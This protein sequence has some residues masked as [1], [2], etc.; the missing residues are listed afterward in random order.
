MPQALPSSQAM[1]HQ[2]SKDEPNSRGSSTDASALPSSVNW[3]NANGPA[4]RTRTESQAA[5]RSSPSPQFADAVLAASKGDNSRGTSA[6]PVEKS[7]PPSIGESTKRGD[8]S[9]ASSSRKA[10]PNI[11]KSSASI[12]DKLIESV[13]S[14]DFR[15]VFDSSAFSAEEL[16]AI[17]RC[18]DLIDPYGGVKRRL[19]RDRE[20]AER[21]KLEAEDPGSSF[22]WTSLQAHAQPMAE[23]ESTEDE[24]VE[25]GSLALGGEPEDPPRNTLSRTT[26]GRPSSTSFMNDQFSNIN[27]NSRNLTP[28]EQ[29]QLALLKS[30][31]LQRAPGLGQTSSQ[32]LGTK[33]EIDQ[34]ASLFQGQQPHYDSSHV[35]ARNH[36]RYFANDSYKS[37]QPP[38]S[39]PQQQQTPAGS[40]HFYASGVQ[41]PPPGLKTAGT[42][43]ISGG[44]MFAQGHG[45]T[46]NMNAGFGTN[47]DNNVDL[48]MR[49]RT[50][51]TSGN[52]FKREYLLS[53]QNTT[54][55]SPPLSAPAHGLF[56]SLH[57]P[58]A[59]AYQ[60][61]TLIK[62]NHH[63]KKGK[64]HGKA[65]T[66]SSGGGVV[67]L[68][69][70]N[71]S[72]ARMHLTNT[73][74][75]QGLF[76]GHNQGGYNQTNSIYSGG[77]GRW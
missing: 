59:V 34:R 64:K 74:T 36:S 60:D 65:N 28:H 50:G 26:I 52:H 41:G 72:Q 53:L 20:A 46:S 5:S 1:A 48:L 54:H 44:G 24:P 2:S 35:H 42:P 25:S 76:G 18:P 33:F 67:D 57:G 73:G 43:P 71:L 13:N 51:T 68:A 69:D 17:D 29:Q 21:A 55:R 63:K 11:A 30:T 31:G 6:A 7:L 14:P 32:A 77:H 12:F 62:H 23:Q 16:E 70:P 22:S 75:G 39:G 66:S 27:L 61:P 10:T 58:Y 9:Q 45:F 3:A 38:R 40:Q 47:K 8:L 19:M 4:S 49:G 56:D 37:A 15:F